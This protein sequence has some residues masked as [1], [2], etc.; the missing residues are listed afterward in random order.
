MNREPKFSGTTAF[1]VCRHLA[2]SIGVRVHGLETNLTTKN[3]LLTQ[4]SQYGLENVHAEAFPVLTSRQKKAQIILKKHKYDGLSFGLSGTT[5]VEG[6]SGPVVKYTSW[7]WNPTP[8]FLASI[9]EKIIILYTRNFSQEIVQELIE[10]GVQGIIHV[11]Y[12]PGI[13]PK[14]P[15]GFIYSALNNGDF[16]ILPPIISVSYEDGAQLLA[17]ARELTIHA[18]VTILQSESYNILGEIP[19]EEPDVILLS[20]HYDTAPYSPGAADN[21]GGT[22]ILLELARIFADSNP[23]WT[24][25]FLATGS[26]ECALQGARSYCKSN[27]S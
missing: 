15:M 16:D 25:R 23:R 17:N 2:Q 20:A 6:I 19:G 10:A 11:T 24:L 14:L 22:A 4:L 18:D 8:Q 21:A 13:P 12:Y 26:E 27:S 9:S 5:E 7:S 3:Y 1:E